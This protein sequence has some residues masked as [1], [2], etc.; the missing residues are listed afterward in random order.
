MNYARLPEHLRGGMKRYIEQYCPT[1][2]F[3]EAV[4]ENNLVEA[5]GRADEVNRERMFDIVNFLYNEAPADCWG[6]PAKVEA[7]LA[8]RVGVKP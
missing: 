5:F 2:G 3:L 4:L 1:G 6:S 7:W 8:Q